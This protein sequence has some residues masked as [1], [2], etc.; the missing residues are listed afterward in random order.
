MDAAYKRFKNVTLKVGLLSLVC[1]NGIVACQPPGP[2]VRLVTVDGE[3]MLLGDMTEEALFDHFP[4][5]REN[6]DAYRTDEEMVARLRGDAAPAE[7]VLFLGTWCPD[8]VSEAPKFLK[9][10]ESVK[11]PS[12]SLRM[13][14]VDRSK[15]DESGLTAR[16][17]L[18]FV[19]TVIVLRNGRELG[20]IVEYPET[21]MEG[22]LVRILTADG[23]T[24]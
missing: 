19:P 12:W 23:A 3:A 8:S 7:F 24:N 14:G 18:E 2:R 11:H 15:T 17:K 6:K 20:R 21:T 16:Y 1:G 10:Y 4:E 13:Y 22:D 9:V 5:F